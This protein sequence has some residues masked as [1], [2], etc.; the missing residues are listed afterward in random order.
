MKYLNR[1]WGMGLYFRQKG[2]NVLEVAL[3]PALHQAADCRMVLWL[4]AWEAPR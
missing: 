3:M 4:R 1:T 2:G